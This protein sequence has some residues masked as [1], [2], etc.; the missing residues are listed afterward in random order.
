MTTVIRS[1]FPDLNNAN[2]YKVAFEGYTEHPMVYETIFNVKDSKRATEYVSAVSGLGM[3]GIKTEGDSMTYDSP[4]QL[5]DGSVTHTTYAQGVR[6]T[7][8]AMQDDEYNVLGE[9]LFR[10]VGRGFNQRV[11]TEAA[12]VFNNGFTDSAA[13]HGPDGKPLFSETHYKNPDETTSYISNTTASAADLSVVALKFAITNFE[14]MTDER[15]LKFNQKARY[16]LVA[17]EN[18]WVA[19]EILQSQLV[20]HEADTNVFGHGLTGEH[21]VHSANTQ[22][23][24]KNV[25][26]NYVN[27]I[28]WPFLTDV[29]SWYLLSDKSNHTL[30]FFWRMKFTVRKDN[31]FNTWDAR[32]GAA[33][34]FSTY[35]EKGWLGA[36]GVLGAD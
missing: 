24:T 18:K 27:L 22:T 33:M 6:L 13:Y 2:F 31:E 12:N 23:N 28:V 16:L 29:N 8:E 1:N 25:L 10:S 9:R 36:Y 32:Y 15:G 30:N 4:I 11:E 26:N 7:M 14:N 3:P 34:R 20:P 17:P 5:Y 21:V 35:W 19:Q